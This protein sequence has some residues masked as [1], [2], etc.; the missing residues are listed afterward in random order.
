MINEGRSG[1]AH[2]SRYRPVL[3]ERV[4]VG[5]N[6]SHNTLSMADRHIAVV[7]THDRRNLS[8]MLPS[9]KGR[10]MGQHEAYLQ[11]MA[12]GVFARIHGYPPKTTEGIL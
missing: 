4:T 11:K 6:Q 10:L 5:R 8:S 2:L 1:W 3:L 9:Q 7:I 12:C